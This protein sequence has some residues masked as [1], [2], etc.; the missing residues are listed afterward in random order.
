M[1]EKKTDPVENLVSE[2]ERLMPAYVGSYIGTQFRSHRNLYQVFGWEEFILPTALYS[3]YKVNGIAA[4]VNDTPVNTA[5]RYYPQISS[6]NKPFEKALETLSEKYDLFET[7]KKADRLSGV[8]TYSI[9]VLKVNGQS[10]ESKLRKFKMNRFAGFEVYHEA[11]VS[12]VEHIDEK[13]NVSYGIKYYRVGQHKIHPSRVIHVAEDSDDGVHGKSRLLPAYNQL[14]DMWKISG[15]TA[16]LYYLNASL[17]LNAK[18]MEGYKVKKKDGEELQETLYEL[19]NKMKGFMVTNGFE[20]DNIAPKITSPKDS[21]EVFEKILSA[22]SGI[23]RRILFGSEMGQLASSQDSNNYFD[24]VESRQNNYINKYL[25]RAV[26]D[27]LMIYSDIPTAEYEITWRR[28][29]S[30][31]D[32]DIAE[33]VSRYAD[34]IKTLVEAGIEGY[35]DAVKLVMEKIKQILRSG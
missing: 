19:V 7:L 2:L 24:R 9:I 23:P 17:L 25:I 31:S 22:T 20:I 27:K 15:S 14:H 21:W 12:L 8:S 30:L 5:W 16:E 10:Y 28:L 34:A 26:I 11:E 18:A 29:S 3:M 32:K 13:N 4:A 6:G 1:T 33:S 35:E